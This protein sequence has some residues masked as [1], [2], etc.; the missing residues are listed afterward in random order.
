MPAETKTVVEAKLVAEPKILRLADLKPGQQADC[1]ALLSGRERATTRDGKPYYR[2]TF[3]DSAR[4]ATVMVW[5]D[6][7]W[8]EAC[9][10][11]WKI[12]TCYK[13]RGRLV[14][15]SYGPQL[16]LEKIRVADESDRADGFDETSL[17]KSTRFDIEA[18]FTE[19]RTLAAERIES[20]PLRQL[21]VGILD[22]HADAIK[23]GSA[24]QKNHHAYAGGFLEHVLSVTRNARF[25]ADKYAADYPDMQPPLNKSLVIAGAILHDIGKLIELEGP[26]AGSR[27]T[28]E[29]ELI[30]H[31]VLGR[32][33]VRDRGRSVEG[34]DR[35][36]LL[37]LEHIILAHQNLPEWGS[38]VEPRTPEAL[39]VYFAD[40]VDAKFHMLAGALDGPAAA[41]DEFTSRD[42]PMRRSVFRGLRPKG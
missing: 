6:S 26:L 24:A 7:P 31:I 29:G 11:T 38:P 19:L 36:T 35:E 21:V 12:G 32:D 3:R 28:A 18:M 17:V 9:D 16:E 25:L 5:S 22:E 2:V 33:L 4:S 37:R 1:F 42:N 13:I 10:A 15:S 39:L 40:D 34:L 27:R 23:R 14:E 8:F 20:E 41:E 30:G